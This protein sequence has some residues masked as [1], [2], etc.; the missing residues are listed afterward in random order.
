MGCSVLYGEIHSIISNDIPETVPAINV[1]T[2]KL[3]IPKAVHL[4]ASISDIVTAAIII[5]SMDGLPINI[6]EQTAKACVRQQN[7]Q[8]MQNH[9]FVFREDF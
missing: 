7:L 9:I 8:E 2:L 1:P 5:L 6:R 4:T 3:K